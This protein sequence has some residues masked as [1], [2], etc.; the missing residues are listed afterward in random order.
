VTFSP[1]PT[2]SSGSSSTRHVS[3]AADAALS[4]AARGGKLCISAITL[5]ELD[6]LSTK[7]S[8]PYPDAFS[9]IVALILDPSAPV[10]VLPLALEVAQAM[11]QVP[12]S[13]VPDMPDGII[14]ATAV[15]HRLPLVPVDSTI[16]GSA[17][18]NAL[19]RVIW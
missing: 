13:E 8:F 7:K 12:R 16:Q 19:I 17:A 10:E 5:V 11:G 14:A 6:Y 18:L 1:I 2:R 15:A 9:R 4:A 3:P